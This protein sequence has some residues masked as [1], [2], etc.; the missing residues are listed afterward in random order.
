MKKIK[1]QRIPVFLASDDNY[2]PFLAVTLKSIFDHASADNFY[3]IIILSTDLSK[4]NE[5]KINALKTE[6]SSIKFVSMKDQIEKIKSLFPIRDYYSIETYYRIFIADLFPQYDK[7][8]YLDCDVVTV[9]DIAELY[10]VNLG[11]NLVAAAHEDVADIL[12]VYRR[13]IRYALDCNPRKY[14]SAGILLMNTKL[15]RKEAFSRKFLNLMSK[16]TFRITQDEDYLNVLCKGRTRLLNLGWNRGA[17]PLKSFKEK[18]LKIIHYKLNWKP[19]KVDDALYE[20]HFWNYASKTPY[21]QI[22]ADRKASYSDER[23]RKDVEDFHRLLSWIEED[24]VDPYNYRNAEV[25]KGFTKI[26]RNVL[27]AMG[28]VTYVGRFVMYVGRSLFR[29]A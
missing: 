9:T 10:N 28:K 6:N 2:A 3:E 13:Y 18:N 25:M 29:T 14:F 20:D 27:H 5:E 22:I 4:D 16:Y 12:E 23:K 8:I 7:V 1:G 19:W 11:N 17:F 26:R 15:F 24:V 21:G